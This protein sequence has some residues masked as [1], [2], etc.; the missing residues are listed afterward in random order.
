LLG[1][2]ACLWLDLVDGWLAFTHAPKAS[3][4]PILF[5]SLYLGDLKGMGREGK[6]TGRTSLVSMTL[7]E[8]SP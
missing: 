6:R 3:L 7:N 1:V 8:L 5:L 4:I 2:T